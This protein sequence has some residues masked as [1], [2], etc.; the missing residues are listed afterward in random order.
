MRGPRVVGLEIAQ[1]VEQAG[2][3]VLAT[4]EVS[5]WAMLVSGSGSSRSSTRLPGEHLLGRADKLSG[6]WTHIS[7]IRI[8][9]SD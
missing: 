5:R 6:D 3:F 7:R 2:L 8:S 4:D 1:I 9:Q